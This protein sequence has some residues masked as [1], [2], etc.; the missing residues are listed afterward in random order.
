MFGYG[1][2]TFLTAPPDTI[3]EYLLGPLPGP[4]VIEVTG[5][6]TNPVD[7]YPPGEILVVRLPPGGARALSDFLWRDIA[8][9]AVGRP[10]LVGPGPFP[11]S[12][13]Y[14][15]VTGYSLAHT[16]NTWAADALRA[17]GLKLDAGGVVFSGQV[18]AR[19]TAAGACLPGS[20]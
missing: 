5:V 10:R 18:V 2:K 19:A 7:A 20:P 17:A 12:L 15:A 6:G 4:A 8:R 16:C 11:G 13:F 9:D 14:A 1:K 3:S